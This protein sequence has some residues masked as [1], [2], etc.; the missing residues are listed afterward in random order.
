MALDINI[1]HDLKKMK[2][3]LNALEYKSMPRA[4]VRTINVLAKKVK[5]ASSKN[6]AGELGSR[7]A[8]VKRRINIHK[9][10]FKRLWATL[11]AHGRSLQLIEFVV[12]SKKATQQAG[13]KRGPVRTKIF[14][15][16]KSYKQAFIAPR[17]SGDSKTT[18]YVRKGKKRKPV[19]MMFGPGIEALFK[20][21]K[22]QFVLG[23]LDYQQMHEPV[24][25]GWKVGKTHTWH[26]GRNRKSIIETGDNLTIEQIEKDILHS[27]MVRYVHTPQ[28]VMVLCF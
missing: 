4:T 9:A 16:R 6:I 5:V 28:L 17:R 7:Q 21:K 26:G 15:K 25:Y 23:R 10:S 20:T 13:G 27:D 18:V 8:G 12:G 11:V 14:G 24:L 3:D 2:R 1:Q 19:R 22:N